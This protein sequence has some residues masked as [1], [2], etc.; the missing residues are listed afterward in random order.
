MAL[1]TLVRIEKAKLLGYKSELRELMEGSEQLERR[2]QENSQKQEQIREDHL[3][4]LS[5]GNLL[6]ESQNHYFRDALNQ[7]NVEKA[8]LDSHF[9][10]F[11]I[12]IEEIKDK[13]S[14]SEIYK[15]SCNKII[16]IRAQKK[17]KAEQDKAY[18]ELDDLVLSRERGQDG[19]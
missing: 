14:D 3:S 1:N 18:L 7:L 16:E 13:I 15:K 17:K 19:H 9:Q 8:T 5:Q 4:V 12:Q 6:S 11:R 10:A 2:I